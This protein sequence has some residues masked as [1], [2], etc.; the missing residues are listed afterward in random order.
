MSYEQSIIEKF[1]MEIAEQ[2]K[3]LKRKERFVELLTVL[4]NDPG[5]WT[6][7]DINALVAWFEHSDLEPD[8][9]FKKIL[10]IY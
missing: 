8:E 3:M 7:H 9:I 2:K 6:P 4:I 10:R 1:N 5:T